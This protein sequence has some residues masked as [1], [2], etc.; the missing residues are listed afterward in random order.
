VT[1]TSERESREE[2]E[3]YAVV[4]S[5][6][7]DAGLADQQQHVL[8]EDIVPAV[9]AAPGFV[10][11]YWC[12]SAD[13]TDAVSFVTFDDRAHAEQFA[14]YVQSDPHGRDQNGVASGAE[15]LRVVEVI[16]TA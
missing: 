3:M 15:G 14:S 10:S 2:I 16:A 5:W 11:A 9:K 8:K 4:G 13:W 12:H 7:M 1:P 6:K